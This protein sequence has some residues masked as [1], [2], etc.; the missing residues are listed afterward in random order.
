MRKSLIATGLT[1]IISVSLFSQDLPKTLLWRISG[2]GLSKPSYVYGTMH[3]MDPRIF[4]LGDSLMNA[5][6]SSE[7]FANEVD[8]NQMTAFVIDFVKQ[9]ISNEVFLKKVMAGKT[10]DQYGAALAKKF[11][12]PAGEI[13]TLDIL[14]EKNKWIDQSFKGKKMQTFLD[15]YLME[16]ADKQG[17]WIGGIED[18]SDQSGLLNSVDESDIREIAMSD[19]A[20]EKSQMEKMKTIYLNGDLE[21]LQLMINGMDSNYRDQLLIK[22]NHKMAFRM[23][24]LAKVRSMVF[25]VGC[26]HLPGEEG[27]IQLLRARGFNVDPVFS[28]KLIKPEEYQVHEVVRPW[29]EANDPEGNYKV[30]MP[31]MPGNLRIFGIAT[32]QLYFNIFNSTLYMTMC[33]SMPYTGRRLDSIQNRML[34]QMFG[35]QEY[36]FEKNLEINGIPGKSFIQKSTDGYRKIY[37]F[38]KENIVYVAIGFSATDEET[39]VQP[40]NRFLDSYQP[41]ILKHDPDAKD[42]PYVD[43][44]HFYGMS[45]PSKPNSVDNLPASDK[46]V[47]TVLMISTEPQ[48]AT[49]YFCGF[50]ECAKGYA[51]QNDSIVL[52]KAHENLLKK[53]T[54]ITWDTVYTK[55]NRRTLEMNGSMLNGTVWARTI[56]RVRGNRTYTELV[57]YPPGKWNE[58]LNKKLSSFHLD[59]Y[60]AGNWA[61]AITPDSLF[62]T[63]APAGIS[64]WDY[65]DQKETSSFPRYISFDSSRVHS[66]QMHIDTLATYRWEK[67]D[68]TLWAQEKDK[69]VAVSDTLLSEKIFKKDGL[70]QYEFSQKAKGG[71]NIMRMH[72]WLRGNLIYRM[73]TIQEPETINEENV[74]RF[75]D[76]FHF[77]RL[78]EESRIFNSKA[79]RLLSDLQSTDTLISRK[80]NKALVHAPFN[81]AEIPLLQKALLIT[82]PEDDSVTNSTNGEI[83]E[84]IIKLN[85]SASVDFARKHFKEAVGTE[86]KCAL[87]DIISARYTKPNYDSLGRLLIE[88]PPKF[89]FP[90]WVTGKWHDSL[91]IAANLFPTI[92]PLINDS[93]SGPAIF[94]LAEALLDDSLLSI[95]T[96]HPWQHSILQYADRR[97][98]KTL[99]D[100]VFYTDKDYSVI[101]VLQLMKTDS[102]NAMLKK[103]LGVQSNDYHKQAI[104][105]SLLKNK[106]AINPDVLLELAANEYTRLGLYQN[107]KEYQKTALYPSKYLTQ[108]FFAASLAREAAD[109]FNDEESDIK[110]LTTREINWHGKLRRFFFYDLYLKTDSEHYLVVAGPFNINK[111]IVSFS[112]AYRD[113]YSTEQYD[114]NKLDKQ[115]KALLNQINK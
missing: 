85:D 48:S 56:I 89:I 82:Y 14:K 68:S 42:F 115:I 62:T 59:N 57:M 77:N 70:F 55:N 20:G 17:K 16:L 74:N 32:M 23:D 114:T 26:A 34:S 8:M 95:A 61:Y 80:A 90:K 37:L 19:G 36:K 12:K 45:M 33:A 109:E 92:M 40:V 53:L 78:S 7:G 47:R 64:F 35:G 93:L 73:T 100:T 76:Q 2:N 81:S 52:D 88:S 91:Q 4:I 27:L 105:L 111:T 99:A 101:S 49:Y 54:D 30:M 13:T 112:D 58:S 96:F 72:M 75:F 84:R 44:K 69:F 31:A 60:A 87:L 41:I 39:S 22:R 46:S 43:S 9:E 21:G 110:L 11:N 102:G 113:V 10:F 98:R 3:V 106:Q 86:A 97:F 25:A 15:A 51:F 38:N 104:V 94:D 66:Y 65:K 50:T 83:A 5:I 107:L 24:S 6:K 108:S 63:W 71:N 29:V 28:S 1:L 18:F 67:N 79:E 103:W